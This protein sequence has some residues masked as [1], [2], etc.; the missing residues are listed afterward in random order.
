MN[1]QNH[2]PHDYLIQ[3]KLDESR[4]RHGRRQCIAWNEFPNLSSWDDQ[5]LWKIERVTRVINWTLKDSTIFGCPVLSWQKKFV[6]PSQGCVQKEISNKNP[7]WTVWRNTAS[8]QEGVFAELKLQKDSLQK[9]ERIEQK[10]D[11]KRKREFGTT[12]NSWEQRYV[13]FHILFSKMKDAVIFGSKY[14]NHE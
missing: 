4:E 13:I 5:L 8:S 7:S 10:S 6:R 12:R 9:S 2:P 11:W 3:M 1:R 14:N